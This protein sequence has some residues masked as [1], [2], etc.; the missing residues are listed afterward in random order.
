MK[1]VLL[2]TTVLLIILISTVPIVQAQTTPQV[3]KRTFDVELGGE[4][5]LD[6]ELGSID[7]KTANLNKVKIVVTKKAEKVDKLLQEVLRSTQETFTD[8][9]VAEALEDFNVTFEEKEG[10]VNIIGK[11]KTGKN[12]W[13]K[14]LLLLSLLKIQF[15]VTIPHQYSVNLNTSSD[16]VSVPDLLGGVRVQTSIGD[17]RIGEVKGPVWGRTSS[18]GSITLKG[19]Q[20][21]VDLEASIGDIDL[22]NVV[23][24]VKAKT[25]SSGN[26][27]L[28]GCQGNVD[29]TTSIGNIDLGDVTGTVKVIGGDI[30]IGNV[31]DEVI[32]QAS[33]SGNIILTSCKNSVDVQASIGDIDLGDVVG[34]VKVKTGSSGSITLKSCKSDVDV[35]ASIGDVNLADITGTVKASG[36]DIQISN[37][38]GWLTAQ[39]TSSGSITLTDCKNSVD[40]QASIGDIDLTNITGTVKAKTGSSGSITLTDCKNSV[41]VQASI[42][43]VNLTN[44]SGTVKAYGGDIEISNVGGEVT[45]QATSSGEITLTDCKSNVDVKTSIG[46]IDLTNITGGVKAKTGGSGNIKVMNIGGAVEAQASIGD[47]HF[48]NVKGSVSAKTSGSGNITLNN[49]QSQ[50]SAITSIGNIRAEVTRHPRHQWTLETSGSGEIIAILIP[51][52]S[53]DI[54]AQTNRGNISS[55]FFVQGAQSKNILKGKINGGGSLVKLRTSSGDIR[56]QKK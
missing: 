51:Q 14:K 28:K 42:G 47:L 1:K 21:N 35:Q 5:T 40:V 10:D 52:I 4:L 31:G 26:I 23:G 17:L 43:D 48:N 18:S 12:Q 32:A 41:D 6:S 37:V 27:I 7:V 2:N 50:V 16:P 34:S 25:G 39:A 11:F 55:A 24:D 56:L 22:G 53:M 30:R 9:D 8:A 13:Q 3:I 46:D 19:C 54:D 44:I 15:E 45:A 49:C 38:G 20:G 33:S 29:L 36:G